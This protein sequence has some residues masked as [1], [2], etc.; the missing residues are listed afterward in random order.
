MQVQAMSWRVAGALLLAI[1]SGGS[2]LGQAA[3]VNEC[4]LLTDPTQLQQCVERA[5]QN[6]GGR[7]PASFAPDAFSPRV[8]QGGA[9]KPPEPRRKTSEPGSGDK[10]GSGD[11][12][13]PPR[14][15]IP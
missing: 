6:Q 10:R 8:M 5:K 11:R 15:K 4:T 2:A 13:V 3:A 9:T 12:A 7:G 14:A 1:A